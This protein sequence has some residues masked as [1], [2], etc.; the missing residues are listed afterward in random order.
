MAWSWCYLEK[1]ETPDSQLLREVKEEVGLEVKIISNSPK[2]KITDN[3]LCNCPIPFH[4]DLHFVGSHIHYAQYYVCTPISS[5]FTI[6]P[7]KAEIIKYKWFSK[8]EIQKNCGIEAKSK[9]I[10]TEAFKIYEKFSKK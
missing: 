10:I 6:K 5:N 3:S 2:I 1:N 9:A 4:A 7:L 8:S